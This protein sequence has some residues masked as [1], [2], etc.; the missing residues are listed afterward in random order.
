MKKSIGITTW[1]SDGAVW[2]RRWV[3]GPLAGIRAAR[4]RRNA[5]GGWNWRI[6]LPSDAENA[7]AVGGEDTLEAAK[8]TASG[9]LFVHLSGVP[10]AERARKRL[11]PTHMRMSWWVYVAGARLIMWTEDDR[12]RMND[13]GIERIRAF[14]IYQAQ[15]AGRPVYTPAG[16][17][18][19]LWLAE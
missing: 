14:A 16:R 4:I 8:A 19:R 7:V 18:E 1:R 2:S 9:V 15:L 17:K 6:Y 12:R 10:G 3:R 13:I 5:D 11:M